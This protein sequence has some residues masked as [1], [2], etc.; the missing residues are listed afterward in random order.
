MLSSQ[1]RTYATCL[2]AETQK[3]LLEVQQFTKKGR[4]IQVKGLHLDLKTLTSPIDKGPRKFEANSLLGKNG[5]ESDFYPDD[6]LELLL[7]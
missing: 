5:G 3:G 4:E 6:W 7:I 1:V 2:E